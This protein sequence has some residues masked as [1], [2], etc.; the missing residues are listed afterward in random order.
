MLNKKLL[1]AAVTTALMAGFGSTQVLAADDFAIS[2]N[3][4]LTSDYRFRGISQSDEDPAIQGGFDAS[5]EPGFYLGTWASSIDFGDVSPGDYSTVEVD[6]YGGWRGPIGDS[7]FGVDVGYAYYQY[8]GSTVD[9]EGDYQ[10]FYVKTS[11]TTLVFGLAYSDDYYAETGEF[12]YLSGDYSYKFMDNLALGLHVGY[13]I[14][15]QTEFDSNGNLT[16][17]GFLSCLPDSNGSV[18]GSVDSNGGFSCDTEE[19]TDYSISLTYSVVG[20]DLTVAY[21]GTDLDEEEVFGTDWADPV[22]VFTIKKVF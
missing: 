8:P 21:V 18:N 19:Y 2:G 15:E 9:P 16:D 5:F 10:E 13:N 6:Y 11:W 22:A 7:D 1:T 4:A 12:W 14:T 3:V 20:V 17:G